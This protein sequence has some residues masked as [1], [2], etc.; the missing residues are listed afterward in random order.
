MLVAKGKRCKKNPKME[1]NSV[2]HWDCQ[3]LP[4]VDREKT[5]VVYTA[6]QGD[7]EPIFKFT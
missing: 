6:G 4:K 7:S 2:N 5:L 1:G 3:H